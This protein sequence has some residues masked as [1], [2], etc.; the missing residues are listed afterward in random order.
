MGVHRRKKKYSSLLAIVQ[1]FFS[2][3]FL[4][5]VI[6]HEMFIFRTTLVHTVIVI[7]LSTNAIQFYCVISCV[8]CL[9]LRPRLS[10]SVFLSFPFETAVPLFPAVGASDRRKRKWKLMLFFQAIYLF[11]WRLG[12]CSSKL[13]LSVSLKG[14]ALD[15]S[16]PPESLRACPLPKAPDHAA[17]PWY[18]ID[19]KCTH[20]LALLSL[21]FM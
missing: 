13:R 4:F 18:V 6:Q 5:F 21:C 16:Q 19:V 3:R 10:L 12:V 7:I 14:T 8:C 2:F 15:A 9:S 17:A 20:F 1:W 11:R